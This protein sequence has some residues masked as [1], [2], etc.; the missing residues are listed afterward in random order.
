MTDCCRSNEQT[1]GGFKI[2]EASC[3]RKHVDLLLIRVQISE[4]SSRMLTFKATVEKQW[5]KMA[6]SVEVAPTLNFNFNILT[7]LIVNILSYF[8]ASIGNCQLYFHSK[9]HAKSL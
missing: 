1:Q 9:I 2:L 5:K 8:V 7:I 3:D 4:Y 6:A